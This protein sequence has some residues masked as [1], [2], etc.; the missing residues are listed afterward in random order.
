MVESVTG[1]G[2]KAWRHVVTINALKS[3]LFSVI[4]TISEAM[5][6]KHKKRVVAGW[7]RGY[8]Y[9]IRR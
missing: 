4:T 6:K 9:V 2:K 8:Y 5:G 7:L 3:F 1:K